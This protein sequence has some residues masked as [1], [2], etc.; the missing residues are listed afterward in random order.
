MKDRRITVIDYKFGDERD[1]YKGQVKNYMRLL[2]KLYP[3]H[4]VTGYL[5]YVKNGRTEEV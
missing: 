4:K 1:N 3:G 5:W 2:R